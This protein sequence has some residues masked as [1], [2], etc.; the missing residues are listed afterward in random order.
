MGPLRR[1][2]VGKEGGGVSRLRTPSKPETVKQ[3]GL[4]EALRK[5]GRFVFRIHSGQVKVR[6]GFMQLAPKGTPDLYVLGFGWME[7]KTD[8]GELSPEQLE[9]HARIRAAGERVAV[10]RSAKEALEAVTNV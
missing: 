8:E 5:A 9:M 4:V 7:T 1:D 3:A 10:V 2:V 6:R